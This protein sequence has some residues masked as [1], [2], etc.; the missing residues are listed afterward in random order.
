[1]T[2][3]DVADDAGDEL[4]VKDLFASEDSA[5][6][7]ERMGGTFNVTAGQLQVSTLGSGNAVDAVGDAPSRACTFQYSTQRLPTA[8]R[9][10]GLYTRRTS[11]YH[12]SSLHSALRDHR[13][14]LFSHPGRATKR[15][16]DRDL[17]PRQKLL[18]KVVACRGPF[19]SEAVANAFVPGENS[20]P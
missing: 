14:A 9:V 1:M 17:C 20:V 2:I 5:V 10:R 3:Y 6:W 7:T 8:C 15:K 18:S 16:P 11:C 4:L 13:V 12:V 19:P